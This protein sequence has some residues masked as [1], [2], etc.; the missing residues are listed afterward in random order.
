[1]RPFEQAINIVRL[2]IKNIG[3]GPAEEVKF[4]PSVISGG[5]TAEKLLEEFTETNFF[6]TGLK[7]LGP[8]QELYSHYNQM[9][10][11]HDQKIQSVLLFEIEYKSVTGGKYKEK[12]II[13]MSEM[14]GSYQLGKPNLYAIAQSIVKIQKDFGHIVSGFKRIKSDIYTSEDREME[15]QDR[16]KQIEEIKEKQK[17]S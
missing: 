12:T 17:N 11:N 13:D 6:R 14:K 7:Y 3:L 4:I 9:T 16:M 8:G 10:Q 5:E 15:Y 2:H 1:M